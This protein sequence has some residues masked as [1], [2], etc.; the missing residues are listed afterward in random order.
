MPHKVREVYFMG[1]PNPNYAV[2]ISGKWEQKLASLSAHV[3]QLSE[4]F[5]QVKQMLQTRAGETGAKYGM[6]Y[7]E[8]FHRAENR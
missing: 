2:D 4:K 3:S 1:A 6:T 7:A 8:E 5:D